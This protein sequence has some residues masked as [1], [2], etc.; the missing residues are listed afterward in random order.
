MKRFE[1]KVEKQ[2]DLKKQI[3]AIEEVE[4]YLC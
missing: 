4:K 2:D 1:E 3:N